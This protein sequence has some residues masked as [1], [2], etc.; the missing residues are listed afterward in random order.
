MFINSN[1]GDNLFHSQRT[2]AFW[3]N[4]TGP[5]RIDFSM[6]THASAELSGLV[7]VPSK[8]WDN[9]RAWVNYYLL[10][11]PNG[12]PSEP[13]VS[14]EVENHQLQPVQHVTFTS[15]PPTDGGW[16]ELRFA[17][18]KRA[19]AYGTLTRTAAAPQRIGHSSPQRSS[20]S[21]GSVDVISFMEH[22]DVMS[23]GFPGISDALEPF[24]PIVADLAKT[25]PKTSVVYLS[26]AFA[27][28][29]RVCGA[30]RMERLML[31]PRQ[32]RFQLVAYLYS[33]DP[34]TTRGRLISHA[35]LTAWNGT[36]GTPVMPPPYELHAACFDVPK[37]HMIGLG[38]DMYDV[39][40]EPATSNTSAVL[41]VVYGGSDATASPTLVLPVA[42]MRN[43]H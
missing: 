33:V 31:V 29:L 28:G 15:W 30:P 24:L 25:N 8:I 14:F 27:D 18:G 32:V 19:A 5:K 4:Y 36:A 7:G 42:G 21:N 35:P 2:L 22:D 17:L 11:I 26:P 40:Y 38:F 41:E 39:L 43:G 13:Q 1:M 3:Q 16:Q 20:S 37:G 6:G 12:V 9:A 34:A 23:T 10:D